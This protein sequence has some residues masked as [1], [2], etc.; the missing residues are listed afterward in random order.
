M[1]SVEHVRGIL[2]RTLGRIAQRSRFIKHAIG[3][4][5]IA[6]RAHDG[7]AHRQHRTEQMRIL[8][9][10]QSVRSLDGAIG[11]VGIESPC[12]QVGERDAG[13]RDLR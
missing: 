8:P 10:D 3:A 9:H 5:G 7:G 2:G 11:S 1:N 13:F 6:A 4:F 12:L